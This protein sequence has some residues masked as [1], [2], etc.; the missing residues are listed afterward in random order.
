L[1]PTGGAGRISI[2]R[3]CTLSLLFFLFAF[4]FWSSPW[5]GLVSVGRALFR[6]L[7]GAMAMTME[8]HRQ[9]GAVGFDP[10]GDSWTSTTSANSVSQLYPTSLGSN[11]TGFNA[12]AKPPPARTSN[13]SISYHSTT[14]ST[15]PMAAGGGYSMG[16]YGQSGVMNLAQD[17]MNHS[18]P[19]TYNQS[20]SAAPT[21][22]VNSYSSA[23]NMF[24]SPFGN[25]P[26]QSQHDMNRRLSQQ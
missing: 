5:F 12:L 3:C 22:S 18:R 13:P 2:E 11:S 4:V 19:A 26:L 15:S 14:T 21:P 7:L 9:L 20:Y 17:L 23:S 24:L 16:S 6:I 25:I 10:F 8:Q 1:F